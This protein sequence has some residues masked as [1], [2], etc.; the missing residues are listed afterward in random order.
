MPR[1]LPDVQSLVPGLPFGYIETE[2]DTSSRKPRSRA[3]F[4]TLSPENEAS[5]NHRIIGDDEVKK[6][7]TKKNDD[8]LSGVSF[9]AVHGALSGTDRTSKKPGRVAAFA[10]H[11]CSLPAP[12]PADST[13]TQH[14]V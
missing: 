7:P 13:R 6:T 4:N 1:F 5:V 14:T 2:Q 3:D 11:V 12:S 8:D 10:P 9:V